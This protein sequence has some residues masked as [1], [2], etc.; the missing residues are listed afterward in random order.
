MNTKTIEFYNLDKNIKH[1]IG[2][3]NNFLLSDID[4]LRTINS[5]RE[6]IL[7]TIDEFITNKRFDAIGL[8]WLN[9]IYC[10]IQTYKQLVSEEMKDDF[11]YF[12]NYVFHGLYLNETIYSHL[13]KQIELNPEVLKFSRY[14][15]LRLLHNCILTGD[16][17]K[18]TVDEVNKLRSTS[19]KMSYLLLLFDLHPEL[20][21]NEQFVSS[22]RELE[23]DE[24]VY[25]VD[26][27]DYKSGI[28]RHSNLRFDDNIAPS[29]KYKF[30][31]HK[32]I[33]SE[34][35]K[36]EELEYC[37]NYNNFHL[38]FW[39]KILSLNH[40]FLKH[41]I[42][43]DKKIINDYKIKRLGLLGGILGSIVIIVGGLI[44]NK[45]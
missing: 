24:F 43:D 27:D 39:F 29:I 31:E 25:V 2:N 21:P 9:E 4:K 35:A 1:S 13:K 12:E 8:N 30:M 33:K 17:S 16:D 6:S 18:L 40:K 32:Q 22:H 45:F 37:V 23:T 41:K 36:V 7:E 11:N 10:M 44:I 28:V 3:L 15:T 5:L 26:R 34:M 14:E 38:N 19:V 42:A 20:K